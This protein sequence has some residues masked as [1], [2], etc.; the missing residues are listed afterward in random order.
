[1]ALTINPLTGLASQDGDNKKSSDDHFMTY[2]ELGQKL[3]E[4]EEASAGKVEVEVIGHSREGREIYTAR[5]GTGDQVLLINSNIHGNEKSGPEALMQMFETLGTSDSSFAQAVR[6]GVTIVAI[7]RLNVDG[8]EITQRQNIFSWDDVIA[9]Y[10]Q[11]EGADPAWYYSERN[12]GFDI[13]R[14]F[15]PDLNYEPVLE[16]LPGTGAD[17]GFFLTNESQILRDLY[18]DLKD[19]FG[20][21]EAFVDLHHMGTPELNETGE[22]VT[23]AIDYPPLGPDDSSKY[24][25]WPKL[26]QD[27]SKRYSLA[28]ALGVKE[29]SDSE[30]TGVARYLHPEER[31]LPGQARSSFALNGTATVLF[32]MPGQQPEYG[33]DQQLID[34]VEN[35][36]WGIVTRMADNSIDDLNGDDFLNLPKYWTSNL[37]DTE[38]LIDRFFKEGEFETEDAVRSLKVHLAAISHYAE[39]EKADKVVKHIR[40]FKSLLDHQENEELISE[41]AYD[42]LTDDADYLI[43]RWQ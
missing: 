9:T 13:N 26:D 21:V 37:S 3:N 35:G 6:D 36:L 28:A 33:Y 29:F 15:N 17:P 12:G 5:V 14:D 20:E 8:A 22:D 32:E 34:R 18:L 7:P 19:E 11:L 43:G 25:D 38:T 41:K 16:D 31:D 4:I 2:E 1:M 42:R 10:P 30:E 27:K 39:N 24:D 40:S 23:I